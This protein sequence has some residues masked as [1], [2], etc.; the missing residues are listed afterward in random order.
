MGSSYNPLAPQD[1]SFQ[2][3]KSAVATQKP[4]QQQSPW[5]G[6]LAGLAKMPEGI[7]QQSP[8]APPMQG[9][10]AGIT[11]DGGVLSSLLGQYNANAPQPIKQLLGGAGVG[12]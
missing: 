12:R 1:D 9:G 10:G 8:L 5:M 6:M 3:D 2:Q 11:G 7:L 4:G